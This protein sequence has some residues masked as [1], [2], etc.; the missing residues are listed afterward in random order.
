MT[1][2]PCCRQAAR[3]QHRAG[4]RHDKNPNSQRRDSMRTIHTSASPRRAIGSLA[5]IAAAASFTLI[6]AAPAPKRPALDDPTIV[7]IFDAANTWDIEAAAVALKKSH[8][9]DVRS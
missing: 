9:K 3:A 6:A 4:G 2:V 8:N 1:A 5:L 7:A